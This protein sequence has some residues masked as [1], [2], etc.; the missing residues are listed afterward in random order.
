[1][2]L[3]LKKLDKLIP[4]E[5]GD[6][7][8]AATKA[9]PEY[10]PGETPDL[11]SEFCLDGAAKP[12]DALKA[13]VLTELNRRARDEDGNRTGE[14]PWNEWVEYK[15]V[16]VR[17]YTALVARL[18]DRINR[19]NLSREEYRE[20]LMAFG[21]LTSGGLFQIINSNRETDEGKE[22]R[23]HG[24]QMPTIFG[25]ADLAKMQPKIDLIEGKPASVTVPGAASIHVI[26]EHLK[27]SHP[28]YEVYFDITTSKS[29]TVAANF[30]TAGLGDNRL[31]LEV[32]GLMTIGPDGKPRWVND[33][34][35]IEAL[36]GTQGYVCVGSE[37]QLKVR[38]V[39][40]REETVVVN[41]DGETHREAYMESMPRL[42]AGLY[43]YLRERKENGI[44]VDG[45]EILDSTGMTTI[46]RVGAHTAT[47]FARE[48]LESLGDR[49]VAAIMLRVR[50]D[51]SSPLEESKSEEAKSF[52]GTLGYL[53][54]PTYRAALTIQKV[55]FDSCMAM[56]DEDELLECDDDLMEVIDFE[57]VEEADLSELH[58]FC[59]KNLAE[60]VGFIDGAEAL[61]SFYEAFETLKRYELNG[62]AHWQSAPSQYLEH[63][64][65]CLRSVRF[66]HDPV[67]IE[68]LRALREDVPGKRREEAKRTASSSNDRDVVYVL[69][70]IDDREPTPSE[71]RDSVMQATKTV[72]EVTVDTH[73]EV[74][75]AGFN[76]MWN[77]HD[78]FV[79]SEFAQ[80]TSLSEGET[81]GLNYYNGGGN[82]HYAI[83]AKDD[84]LG[85]SAKGFVASTLRRKSEKTSELH[86]KKF[87]C[88]RIYVR[89]GEKHY[90]PVKPK[91]IDEFMHFVKNNR[92][93]AVARM[94]MV[95]V[96]GF[97]TI[98]NFRAPN[99]RGLL[100]QQ[101]L[102]EVWQEVLS[103]IAVFRSTMGIVKNEV[104]VSVPFLVN[105]KGTGVAV[106][107]AK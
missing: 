102:T 55:L 103:Q 45:L 14:F 38:K 107:P 30:F 68:K 105:Q 101:G 89:E 56:E 57:K 98:L 24:L 48:V 91:W 92:K 13:Y 33:P 100:A 34:K 86:G 12:I 10:V 11:P 66:V 4:V 96:H 41:L 87:G 106:S 104:R 18:I 51:E 81:D 58:R 1:M 60:L 67:E 78:D 94:A 25:T 77:G 71:I 65:S 73:E 70:K 84:D 83:N 52:V 29:S 15:G 17:K 20:V 80:T 82:N 62:V 44:W 28:G 40:S 3:D 8:P 16:S 23:V 63:G 90:P 76:G 9:N 75:A 47:Q 35:E 72:L 36:R 95:Y 79:P 37:F 26:N 39:P 42:I 74:V 99:Y 50:H 61:T 97:N 69:E 27:A 43:P 22:Q 85:G 2:V 88:I 59:D 54:E 5:P 32:D 31:A 46:I 93:E 53:T 21:G 6:Y 19:E 7:T 49:S 64:E